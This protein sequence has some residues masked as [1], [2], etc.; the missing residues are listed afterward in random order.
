LDWHWVP[1][2]GFALR[3]PR[4]SCPKPGDLGYIDQP[5]Q[6]YAI[7]E[8]VDGNTITTIDGNSMGTVQRRVRQRAQFTAFFSIAGHVRPDV[9]PEGAS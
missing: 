7:V 5:F 1:G 2:I 3:L 4:T 8:F 9:Q 6:H